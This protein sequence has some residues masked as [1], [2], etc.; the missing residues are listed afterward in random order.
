MENTFM[1]KAIEINIESWRKIGFPIP[2]AYKNWCT[3]HGRE[4]LLGIESGNFLPSAYEL[5][6]MLSVNLPADFVVEPRPTTE[7]ENGIDS[8]PTMEEIFAGKI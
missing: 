7:S 3:L 2:E 6:E 4:D 1:E 8:L 5:A